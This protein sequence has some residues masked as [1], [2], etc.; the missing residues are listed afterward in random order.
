MG[1]FDIKSSKGLVQI[2]G[3]LKAIEDSRTHSLVSDS[4][5]GGN[6]AVLQQYGLP[7]PD[8]YDKYLVKMAMHLAADRENTAG[9]TFAL[10]DFY[11][12]V[13]E[14][15]V[16]AWRPS[17]PEDPND[18]WLTSPMKWKSDSDDTPEKKDDDYVP[19]NPVE[20]R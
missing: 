17:V 3:G 4:F 19:W 16:E 12:R 11:R 1:L 13:T 6:S 7:L 2:G 14:G 20:N 15:T 5:F 9:P 18:Y 10:R 8:N